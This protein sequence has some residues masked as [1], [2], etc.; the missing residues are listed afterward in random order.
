MP[1]LTISTMNMPQEWA[2]N[3]LCFTSF[4]PANLVEATVGSNSNSWD[5]LKR[6]PLSPPMSRQ[7]RILRYLEKKKL[8]KYTKKTIHS[9]RK[10]YA[11]TRPRVRGRFTRCSQTN[12]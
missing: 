9:A 3:Q 8:R 1:E 4:R 6:L 11:Q 5:F 7:E 10:T 12:V 2:L